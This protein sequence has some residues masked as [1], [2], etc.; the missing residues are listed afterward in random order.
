[1]FRGISVFFNLLSVSVFVFYEYNAKNTI[2]LAEE[3]TKL[4][5]NEHH[6]MVT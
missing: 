1:M 5:I 2:R 4:K 3:L 6:K